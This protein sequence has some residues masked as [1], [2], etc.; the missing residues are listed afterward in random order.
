M[1]LRVCLD[2]QLL[3]DQSV[4]RQLASRAVQTF[5][6]AGAQCPDVIEG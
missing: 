1:L 2:Y 6:E 3:C 5:M 4:L